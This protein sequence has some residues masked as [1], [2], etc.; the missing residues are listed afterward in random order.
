MTRK[1]VE[2]AGSRNPFLQ[3]TLQ[4]GTCAVNGRIYY[5]TFVEILLALHFFRSARICYIRVVAHK[6]YFLYSTAC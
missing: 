6:I 1:Y 5:Y 4:N 2:L 3:A